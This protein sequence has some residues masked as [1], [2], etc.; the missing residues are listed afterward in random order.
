MPTVKMYIGPV[1]PTSII[2][3]NTIVVTADSTLITVDSDEILSDE[4]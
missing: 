3:Q 4:L 1:T 2:T